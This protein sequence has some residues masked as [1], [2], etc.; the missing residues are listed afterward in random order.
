MG[1]TFAIQ[2][3]GTIEITETVTID[4]TPPS[5][6]PAICPLDSD[7]SDG[8][9]A[10]DASDDAGDLEAVDGAAPESDGGT[11]DGGE[12]ELDASARKP[13]RDAGGAP[14]VA[15]IKAD[16]ICVPGPRSE[17]QT[18]GHLA[19]TLPSE[20][21][22]Y[23]LREVNA[24]LWYCASPTARILPV[25][26]NDGSIGPGC[27]EKGQDFVPALREPLEG[28]LTVFPPPVSLDDLRAEETGV[29][30]H[31]AIGTRGGA[32]TNITLDVTGWHKTK[33]ASC[34]DFY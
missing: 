20:D 8:G 21:G 30:F 33:I 14:C 31:Y 15:M 28:R 17:Q 23:D 7:S 24:E 19:L 2:D 12:F 18:R 5:W 13:R 32:T 10:R 9:D 26:A 22:D 1:L 25:A 3:N 29:A 27:F 16:P 6:C 11:E 34:G 4:H